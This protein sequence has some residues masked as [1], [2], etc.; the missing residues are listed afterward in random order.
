MHEYLVNG[1]NDIGWLLER[2]AAFWSVAL[3]ARSGRWP[4]RSSTHPQTGKRILCIDYSLRDAGSPWQGMGLVEIHR[5]ASKTKSSLS[6]ILSSLP[7]SPPILSAIITRHI[8]EEVTPDSLPFRL[9]EAFQGDGLVARL[10]RA[11]YGLLHAELH[12][13]LIHEAALGVGR[14]GVG[15][16]GLIRAPISPT[17]QLTLGI[18]RRDVEDSSDSSASPPSPSATLDDCAAQ[19][20]LLSMTLHLRR[21]HRRS[22]LSPLPLTLSSSSSSSSSTNSTSTFFGP[23]L[24][25]LRMAARLIQLQKDLWDHVLTPSLTAGLDTSMFTMTGG[26]GLC[27]RV[28][29]YR[30]HITPVPSEANEPGSLWKL[31][32][33]LDGSGGSQGLN[34]LVRS[35]DGQL[36]QSV[37][38]MVI[39]AGIHQIGRLLTRLT[40]LRLEASSSSQTGP[41]IYTTP[42]THHPPPTHFSQ[43]KGGWQ[44]VSRVYVLFAFFFPPPFHHLFRS[45]CPFLLSFLSLSLTYLSLFFLSI[46]YV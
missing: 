14:A 42:H 4:L 27:V 10:S 38:H 35:G 32:G 26:S 12:H 34:A 29:R 25:P 19:I 22:P 44:A 33:S 6:S 15:E 20:S 18:R 39:L 23:V 43:F 24:R 3:T 16:D 17:C 31:A 36:V 11:R 1:A 9:P 7:S 37:G 21:Q 8:L 46:S 30:A 40:P 2:D 13:H 41:W 28:D 45:L 5:D